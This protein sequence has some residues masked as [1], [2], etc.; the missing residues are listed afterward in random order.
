MKIGKQKNKQ[1]VGNFIFWM[2]VYECFSCFLMKN[3]GA[4]KAIAFGMDYFYLILFVQAMKTKSSKELFL[5][6]LIFIALFVSTIVGMVV[7][8]SE[9]S[10][11]IW[12]ARSEFW[13]LTVL[14]ASVKF[15]DIDNIERIMR[16]FFSFQFL[17]L[18]CAA[19]QYHILGYYQDLN[20]GAFLGGAYQDIF[21][22]ILFA[23][24]FYKY[25]RKEDKL[26]KLIFVA[27]S[28][29][30]IAVVEEEKFIFI[31][32]AGIIAYYFV[33]TGLNFTKV[34]I[35]VG[36]VIAAII[37][38]PILNS[39]N[40]Q[41][42]MEMLTSWDNFIGYATMVGYG[43]ELPRLGSSVIISAKFFGDSLQDFFGLGLG[44]CEDASTISFI[45]TAFYQQW[46][47]LH[48]MWF[49]FQIQFMQTGWVGIILYIAFFA[50]VLVVNFKNRASMPE[51]YKYFAD[52]SVAMSFIAIAVIW[53]SSSTRG[54][55]GNFV[56]FAIAIGLAIS[57]Q[58]NKN[59]K[60]ICKT[61]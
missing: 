40:G 59:N 17:N 38:L 42:S 32:F 35:M 27:L 22:A 53:Y 26:W 23:Y 55:A 30:Y 24:Y 46:S 21:C 58:L 5:P 9:I 47:W 16:F 15:L 45:N 43:Y 12:G 49:T 2:F 48:Y 10:N 31:E 6:T 14:Y 1:G 4:P 34:L 33:S 13:G 50:S 18:A 51:K 39:V 41:D 25:I 28:G 61:K 57:R 20:N 56:F 60:M 29:L 8:S 52:F 37:A 3:F 36:S 19:Y 44:M 54:Q 11:F 7:N